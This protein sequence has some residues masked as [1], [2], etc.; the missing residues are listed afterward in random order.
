[1]KKE[2][3]PLVSVIINC[4]NGEKFLKD[5]I[6]SIINQTYSNLEL[7]FWDNKSED[8]SAKIIKEF[9]DKRIK[10]FYSEKFLS[11]YEARNKAINRSSGEY[12]TILDTDDL[13]E[14]NKIEKQL[15]FFE[16]NKNAKILY[17]NYYI[18]KESKDNCKLYLK[19]KK[20]YG[21]ITQELLNSNSIGIITIMV[22]RSIFNNFIFNSNYTIIGEFDFYI[23][24]S[25]KNH[26]Y[27]LDL[28]LAYYRW[29]G[30]NLSNQRIDI[31]LQEFKEWY[32]INKKKLSSLGFS[33]F[34]LRIFLIKLQI[35][36]I[37][38][39]F[40]RLKF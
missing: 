34:N 31:Y 10:Y 12:I 22:K 6:S 3:K 35:K 27:Y 15:D 39:K 16:K 2:N 28:P 30:G 38:K 19:N 21:K 32:K 24:C 37:L 1:M 25:L 40:L 9:E 7:I 33:L 14:N 8:N 23:N 5:C 18:F 17:T 11:L 36:I 20:P 4:H 26:V 29:H 13:W